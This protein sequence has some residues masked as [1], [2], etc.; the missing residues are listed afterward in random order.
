MAASGCTFRPFEIPSAATAPCPAQREIAGWDST[1]TIPPGFA[2]H[3][4]LSH[5]TLPPASNQLI[6]VKAKAISTNLTP[7]ALTPLMS[8]IFTSKSFMFLILQTGF[9][10]PA[11]AGFSGWEGKGVAINQA[12]FSPADWRPPETDSN[13]FHPQE[14]SGPIWTLASADIRNFPETRNSNG[15]DSSE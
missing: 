2:I 12:I 9:Q 5:L 1:G 10:N 4:P 13:Y 11:P 8:G 15:E 7:T 14:S 3:T 6:M